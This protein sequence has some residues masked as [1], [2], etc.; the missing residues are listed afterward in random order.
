[1]SADNSF[2]R[3]SP[4]KLQHYR[5]R[6]SYNPHPWLSF[7]GTINI[8]ESSDNV[9]TVNHFAHNQDFSFA[10]AINP[11]EKWG[12]DLNY[13]YDSVYSR[14]DECYIS[15]A[16]VAGAPTEPRGV[17]ASG[18]AA[19]KQRL[20]QPTHTLWVHRVL[21]SP[22]E[23]APRRRRLSHV[24]RQRPS[25]ANQYPTGARLSAVA[26]SDPLCADSPSISLQTGA[27][28]RTT[29]TTAMAK[30]DADR[31]H[32]SSQLPRECLHSRS[33]LCFLTV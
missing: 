32:A 20:L 13:A 25:P 4:R 21:C 16:P 5:L 30:E 15:S 22:R 17:P 9:Q 18:P 8:L 33:S 19:T 3:I 31:T 26:I 29:T 28:R 24:R 7:A 1:M 11:N 14:T 27:G 2:T 12:I 23:E 10:T 6:T